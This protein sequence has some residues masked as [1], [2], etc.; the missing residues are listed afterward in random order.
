[1]LVD[2]HCHLTATEMLPDIEQVMIRAKENGVEKIV[3]ICT[4]QETLEKGIEV[5]KRHKEIYLTAA[6][7]PHDVVADG[8]YFFPFVEKAAENQQLIA[9]GETGL[10]Y[11]YE[12]APREVQQQF[13]VRYLKLA[14]RFNLPLIFHCRDAFDDLYA[15]T[16]QEKIGSRAILHCFTG[17]LE[18]AK[19][20][21]ERG[22]YISFSGIITFKKSTALRDVV[23]E[24]PLNR[25]LIETDSPFLA[26]QSNR[27]KRNEPAFV[28]ETAEM[29]ASIKELSFGELAKVTAQNAADFFSFEK[30]KRTL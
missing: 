8:E 7:T 20:G 14:K 24:M 1:M 6:T 2:T 23:K 9:I 26:P 17:T 30:Q 13:M 21:L 10:D 12:H 19:A 27:G 4:D 18:E 3:N 22:W 15:I 5:A 28:K 16:D 11:F 25:I 29:I